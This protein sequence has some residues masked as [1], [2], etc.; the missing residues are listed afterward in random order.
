MGRVATFLISGTHRRL[1]RLLV[2]LFAVTM[3]VGGAAWIASEQ[4]AQNMRTEIDRSLVTYGGL[5]SNI[6]TIFDAMDASLTASPCSDSFRREMRRIAFLPDGVNELLYAPDGSVLCAGN[7]GLLAVPMELGPPDIAASDQFGIALWLDRSLEPIGLDALT[8]TIARRGPFALVTPPQFIPADTGANWLEE[9]LVYSAGAG[10]WLHRTGTEG[11]HAAALLAPVQ[12]PLGLLQGALYQYACDPAGEH[13]VAA[14]APL[15]ALMSQ[16]APAIGLVLA[17]LAVLAAWLTQQACG[18]VERHWS[19]EARFLRQF[20]KGS[21]VCAYQPLLNLRT[22]RIVGCEVLARWRDVDG[23]IVP[24]DRFLP[25]IEKHGLTERFT[26]MVADQAHAELVARLT[27]GARLQV[28]FNIFPQDLDAARLIAIYAP[29]LTPG[30]P[31]DLVVELVETAEVKPETAQAEI[32]QLRAAGIGVYI[33]D[34]GAGYSSMHSLAALSVEG[35][36][37]DRSFAMAPD[38]SV[39]ARMLDHAIDLIQASGRPLV[40]EGVETQQRLDL[41]KADGRADF[42]QGYAIARPLPLEAF[43]AFF[44]EHGPHPAANSR[45]VA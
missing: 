25:I 24:P 35:V 22:D 33:D 28:N 16:G 19:F 2:W 20:G 4:V 36:K 27:A 31:F 3:L 17:A 6:V 41:L 42:A 11:V 32:E 44:A 10:R 23:T 40:V 26:A 5:R 30:S 43:I 39:M 7:T 9:E 13:C 45:L 37:L 12:A 29:F 21:L 15:L 34:F 1:R 18:V 38:H 8:G 14:R